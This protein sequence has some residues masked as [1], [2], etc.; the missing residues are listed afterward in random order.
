MSLEKIALVRVALTKLEGK[1]YLVSTKDEFLGEF[2]PEY[3][4]RLKWLSGFSGSNGYLLVTE[5][6]VGFLTDGRYLLQSSK[7][8]PQGI[9]IYDQAEISLANFIKQY[10]VESALVIDGFCFSIQQIEQLEESGIKIVSLSENLLDKFWHREVK[11]S[12]F[13]EIHD[14]KYAGKSSQDKEAEIRNKISLSRGQAYL[15]ADPISICWF[16]NLRGRDVDTT[17]IIQSYLLLKD[18]GEKILF[19][20]IFA[21]DDRI[22]SYFT[23][24]NIVLYSLAE[25]TSYFVR[26]DF[27]AIFCDPKLTNYG[28][29]NLSGNLKEI[30]DPII[31][32]KAQKNTVE[33]SNIENAHLLDGI[34]LTE[35]LYDLENKQIAKSELEAV[36]ILE[37]YRC[38]NPEYVGASFA[39]IMGA[40]SN[41][42]IIHYR[43]NAESNLSFG[44]NSL[45]LLDSGGQYQSGTTDVTR[46]IS[47]GKVSNEISKA[48]S[49]VLKGHIAL[50]KAV[51]PK[52]TKGYQL[53]S[54]AR[55]FLWQNNMDY[56]HGTGHGV[57]M[58][59]NVHEGPQSI[60]KAPTN[61]NLAVGMVVSNEP[62]Y[63][64]DGSFGIRIE[65]LQRVVDK[66][67]GYL[68]FSNLTLAPYSKKLIDV[69]LLSKEEISWLNNYHKD[70]IN[71]FSTSLPKHIITW[72][73][74]QLI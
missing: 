50:A 3:R 8:L 16:L 45:I 59:L 62:G 41:G 29:K 32:L 49:L 18:N 1:G 39:T 34:A 70:L 6:E 2:V 25:L 17:P 56:A 46:V 10:A 22:K 40:D 43:A 38:K 15:I 73:A 11:K 33:I 48:Y 5:N 13:I 58:F 71:K 27:S 42:A 24:N 20:D 68:S 51:F 36:E 52:G 4:E 7:E 65:N 12:E 23:E 9:K 72:I 19:A 21:L 60:S 37:S 30:N 14:L 67:N 74:E 64:Q 63:Y 53:D 26:N 54:L 44:D 47:L 57:G 35:F 66:G 31:I 55:Q 69:S 61:V 28:F